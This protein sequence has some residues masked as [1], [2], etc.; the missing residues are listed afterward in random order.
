MGITAQ[1]GQF[2]IQLH[3]RPA[4]SLLLSGQNR[5]SLGDRVL[6]S[7]VYRCIE[8]HED[9]KFGDCVDNRLYQPLLNCKVCKLPTRHQFVR[10]TTR[11]APVGEPELAGAVQ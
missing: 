9:R 8:C 1:F 4:R 3:S 2:T 10:I 11:Q 6:T 5:G 7:A